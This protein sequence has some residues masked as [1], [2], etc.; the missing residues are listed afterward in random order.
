MT[1]RG[2]DGSVSPHPCPS[3][4]EGVDPDRGHDAAVAADAGAPGMCGVGRPRTVWRK[5]RVLREKSRQGGGRTDQ[6][7][8]AAGQGGRA[9]WDNGFPLRTNWSARCG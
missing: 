2:G 4:R 7:R 3:Y 9:L 1:I 6:S 5:R 8:C